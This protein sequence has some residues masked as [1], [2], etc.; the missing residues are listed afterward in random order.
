MIL[1]PLSVIY[2][3]NPKSD[4]VISS[5]FIYIHIATSI[6]CHFHEKKVQGVSYQISRVKLC[7]VQQVILL[8]SS[9]LFIH[10]VK[11]SFLNVFHLPL[12][13]MFFT[14]FLFPIVFFLLFLLC[15]GSLVK[16]SAV[17]SDRIISLIHSLLPLS[18][19][20]TLSFSL[21]NFLYV[22]LTFSFSLSISALLSVCLPACLSI[23][24]SIYLNTYILPFDSI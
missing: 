14:L 19:S 3:Y 1:I 10:F 13:W 21:S 16:V 17:T 11:L 5:T 7:P 6:F 4:H 22:S 15:Q 24:L 18:L 8:K 2:N 20:H 9:N 12:F 23:H